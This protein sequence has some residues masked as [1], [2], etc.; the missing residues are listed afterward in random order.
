MHEAQKCQL[1][2]KSAASAPQEQQ[3]IENSEEEEC[4]SDEDSEKG[5]KDSSNNLPGCLPSDVFPRLSS[6]IFSNAF[7]CPFFPDAER[8][9]LTF[10][11][12]LI[13]S[14][15]INLYIAAMGVSNNVQFFIL[16]SQYFHLSM[17]GVMEPEMLLQVAKRKLHQAAGCEVRG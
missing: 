8:T 13:Y 2:K 12:S 10:D 16:S 11:A 14:A 15:G 5:L 6:P 3:E 7:E 1:D 17:L 4:R 9:H